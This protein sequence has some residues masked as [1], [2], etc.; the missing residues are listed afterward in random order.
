[1]PSHPLPVQLSPRMGHAAHSWWARSPVARH[2]LTQ[3][4]TARL[5]D[6]DQIVFDLFSVSTA[7]P[8]AANTSAAAPAC[9]KR[10]SEG[11]T[12][13]VR[14]SVCTVSDTSRDTRMGDTCLRWPV[15]AAGAPSSRPQRASLAV[16]SSV[17]AEDRAGLVECA[18]GSSSCS[19][20]RRAVSRR[21]LAGTCLV[22]AAK[23]KGACCRTGPRSALARQHTAR[24]RCR[25]CRLYSR[26]PG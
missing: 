6:T 22:A 18:S 14:A 5:D 12:S 19:R 24:A 26:P 20:R 7:E 4:S 16:G 15:A 1:M 25:R 17:R 10:R 3:P 2:T 11:V 13:K 9:R 8:L 21:P 23:P